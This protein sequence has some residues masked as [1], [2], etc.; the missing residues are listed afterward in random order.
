MSIL[1]LKQAA[2]AQRIKMYY[3]KKRLELIHLL[4]MTKLPDSFTIEKLTIVQLR[5]EAKKRG[6]RGF[7]GLSRD[8][9]VTLLYPGGQLCQNVNKEA[10][11]TNHPEK[12]K[13]PEP[14]DSD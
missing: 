11:N 13:D 9:M 1:E 7:W 10:E 6:L 3:T 12:S 8:D 2:K 14:Y 4:S 5:D